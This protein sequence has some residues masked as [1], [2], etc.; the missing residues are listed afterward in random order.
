MEPTE[1]DVTPAYQNAT[2]RHVRSQ[3]E[4]HLPR[5][6]SDFMV[7]YEPQHSDEPPKDLTP[8]F[9]RASDS[10]ATSVRSKHAHKSHS[11]GHQHSES[12][13]P[14]QISVMSRRSATRSISEAGLRSHP[15]SYQS[16]AG[17]H[18]PHALSPVQ[19]AILQEGIHRLELEELQCQIIEDSNADLECQRLNTKAR[20]AQRLQQEAQEAR[21][22]IAK[23][24]DR[25]RQLKKKEKELQVAKLVTSLLQEPEREGTYSGAASP[26]SCFSLPS[27]SQPCRTER[28]EHKATMPK[29][30]HVGHSLQLPLFESPPTS[31]NQQPSSAQ[32]V[33]Q[34]SWVQSTV[35]PPTMH[36]LPQVALSAAPSASLHPTLTLPAHIEAPVTS[37]QASV[38][39]AGIQGTR[40]SAAGPPVEPCLTPSAVPLYQHTNPAAHFK[41]P[42]P[43]SCTPGHPANTASIR[44]G[45]RE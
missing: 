44:T 40:H 19:E 38:I 4:R 11:L 20:E 2:V 30:S 32:P 21:E 31:Q 28:P 24:L 12:R 37:H 3:R 17:V 36:P 41:V 18:P 16:S 9:L 7:G 23:R 33:I 5:H 42:V 13:A 8:P 25:Q 26:K 29:S 15:A 27:S 6:L 43:P 1:H 22:A 10:R 39:T 34:H 45:P 14:S 35:I